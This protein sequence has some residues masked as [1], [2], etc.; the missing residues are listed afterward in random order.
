MALD[1]RDDEL[2][3]QFMIADLGANIFFYHKLCST[4]LYNK[5]IKK[6]SDKKQTGIDVKEVKATAWDKV[7]AFMNEAQEAEA[8]NGFN[9]HELED[10]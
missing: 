6:S 4:K 1:M 10:M 5:F 9:I 3:S 8:Q 2:A 7:I